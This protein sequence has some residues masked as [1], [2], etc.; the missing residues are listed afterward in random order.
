MTWRRNKRRSLIAMH[1]SQSI[2][3]NRRMKNNHTCNKVKGGARL[4]SV[5]YRSPYDI[6]YD[7]ASIQIHRKSV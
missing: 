2:T 1:H 5:L 4:Q 3:M 6:D 7:D